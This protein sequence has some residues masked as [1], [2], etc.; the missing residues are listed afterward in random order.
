[1]LDL[2]NNFKTC[3]MIIQE[4]KEDIEE[5]RDKVLHQ[6]QKI[7]DVLGSHLFEDTFN[8]VPQSITLIKSNRNT[9]NMVL[10]DLEFK[11][12]DVSTD[13]LSSMFGTFEDNETCQKKFYKTRTVRNICLS[14]KIRTHF[15]Y[16]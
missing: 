16:Y 4:G 6:K 10:P 1:M 8:C 15:T 2:E 7:N 11:P 5:K 13:V 12:N 3:Q 14:C 9:S